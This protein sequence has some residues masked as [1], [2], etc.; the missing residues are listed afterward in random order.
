MIELSLASLLNGRFHAKRGRTTLLLSK[1]HLCRYQR[2]QLF[3][4][5]FPYLTQMEAAERL[6][7]EL[8]IVQRL[9][10]VQMLIDYERSEGQHRY[11]YRRLRIVRRK[12]F[13]DLQRHWQ[14][15][16]P[17]VDVA[18]LLALEPQVVEKL[19]SA[20]LLKTRYQADTENNGLWR[21]DT[22]SVNTF[23]RSLSRY[24]DIPLCFGRPVTFMGAG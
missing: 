21:L 17:L 8:E 20:D 22:I 6:G 5:R 7:I 16:I 12:E 19:V 4:D 9:V 15:G 2:S 10:D 11:E 24:P 13:V 14:T 23:F 3:R 1:T 18:R